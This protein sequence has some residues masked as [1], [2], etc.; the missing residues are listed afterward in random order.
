MQ[1]KWV[2]RLFG[3]LVLIAIGVVFLLNQLGY[4]DVSFW[5]LV[6]D[7][8]PVIL[9]VL[10]LKELAKG[11]RSFFGGAIL[12]LIGAYF[13]GRNLGWLWISPG[14]LF[15]IIIP[16]L[17]I[18]GGLYVIFKPNDRT[19]PPADKRRPEEPA[20]TPE[21]PVPPEPVE[22]DGSS[23]DRQF[24]EKFGI[25]YSKEKGPQG[26]PPK[27]SYEEEVD[28]DDLDSDDDD[29]MDRMKKH[30]KNKY[31]RHYKRYYKHYA[32]E[33][34]RRGGPFREPEDHDWDHHGPFSES[35]HDGKINKSSFIGDIYLGH[36]SFQLK[37][38]NLSQFI[39]DTVLDLTRAH[40]PYGETKI[41]ISAFIGDIKV[42]IP[43]DTDLGV[44]VNSSS[45]IGDMSVLN[46]SRSGFAGNI[47]TR[48]PYYKE[49][50]KKIKIN[51][52]AFIGD[53]KV[54]KVG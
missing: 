37:P 50:R 26:V 19:P 54:N 44:T 18:I 35:D 15:K 24:E 31:K 23:L 25:P 48:T 16:A 40:I 36:D 10:G 27:S 21:P 51:V 4:I 33:E 5:G 53:I 22:L 14:N 49:A 41:N 30:Y 8:W 17:L 9:V 34:A 13:L 2:D 38:T 46:E 3:G 42:Y 20:F 52:S 43:D 1:K 11:R 47:S 39:G 32:R 28:M 12:L 45:F 6:G 7:Y 29:E